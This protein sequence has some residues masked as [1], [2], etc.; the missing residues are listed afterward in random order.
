MNFHLVCRLHD[1]KT[2]RKIKPANETAIKK[3]ELFLAQR[4]TAGFA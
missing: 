2:G 1:R 4:P 3:T